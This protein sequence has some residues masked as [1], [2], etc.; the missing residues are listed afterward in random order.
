MYD[1]RR[2]REI[3]RRIAASSSGWTLPR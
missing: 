3:D 1:M 2:L